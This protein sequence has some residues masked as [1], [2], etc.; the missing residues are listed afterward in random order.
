MSE[1]NQKALSAAALELANSLLQATPDMLEALAEYAQLPQGVFH[2]KL[3]CGATPVM[4]KDPDVPYFRIEASVV[5]ILGLA[6]DVD[7]LDVPK[8][9]SIC[10]E[11]FNITEPMG[12]GKLRQRL[13]A[14]SAIMET[15]DAPVTLTFWTL[16]MSWRS[17]SS[18]ARCARTRATTTPTSRRMLRWAEHN[19][20]R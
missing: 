10:S 3:K 7:E 20:V 12:Q 14:L 5:E 11:L 19:E 4:L 1:T 9:G 2:V 17:R 13:E 8:V 6:D 15:A 16:P 18:L